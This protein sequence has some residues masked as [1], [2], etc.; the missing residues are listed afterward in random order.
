MFDCIIVPGMDIVE[1]QPAAKM[2]MAAKAAKRETVF[3]LEFLK[4]YGKV[5]R[6]MTT[7]ARRLNYRYSFVLTGV[8]ATRVVVT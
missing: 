4:R 7:K 8:P 5:L 6:A 3:I 1:V 2:A